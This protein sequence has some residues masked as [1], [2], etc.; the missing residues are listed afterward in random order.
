MLPGPLVNGAYEIAG[1]LV[2][3]PRIHIP[4]RLFRSFTNVTYRTICLDLIAT[5]VF[6]TDMA[7]L[8]RIGCV[9]LS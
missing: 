1:R 9:C 6:W 2:D 5:N 7:L 4:S 3:L 8:H